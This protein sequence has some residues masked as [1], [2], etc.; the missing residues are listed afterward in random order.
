M[1]ITVML[2]YVSYLEYALIDDSEI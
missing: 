1:K 2:A